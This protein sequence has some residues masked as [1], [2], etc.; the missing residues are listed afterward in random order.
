MRKTFLT[1]ALATV[2]LLSSLSAYAHCEVPCGIYDDEARFTEL[3]EH[4]TTIEKAMREVN[5]LSK[6][7]PAN[8]NQIVRWVTTKETHAN[9]IQDIVTQYFLTQKVKPVA[10]DDAKAL[11]RY[12][13][14]LTDAHLLLVYAMKAKQSTDLANVEKLKT[15]LASFK[16][17]LQEH[18]H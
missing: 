10:G 9:K 12:T 6:A 13:A 18:S 2:T 14:Q 3:A 8:Y 17:S 16:R 4:I 11:A 5:T 7:S 15:V 1:L